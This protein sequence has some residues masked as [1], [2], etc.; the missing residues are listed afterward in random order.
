VMIILCDST[1]DGW[2]KMGV[3][4]AKTNSDTSISIYKIKQCQ[5]IF[6]RT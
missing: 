6:I 4:I 3:P 1:G 5:H 2:L